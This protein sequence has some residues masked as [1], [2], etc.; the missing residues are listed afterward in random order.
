[1]RHREAEQ[2][3]IDLTFEIAI[4][5][6]MHRKAFKKKSREEVAAWVADQLKK[7]GYPTVPCGMSWGVLTK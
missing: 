5:M 1:M 3:L 4:T 6:Q 7:C 2:K